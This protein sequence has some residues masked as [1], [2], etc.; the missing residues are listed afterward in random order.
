MTV[1]NCNP[2]APS[3][4]VPLLGWKHILIQYHLG[5]KITLIFV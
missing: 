2:S 1:N 3:L 4:L 5:L